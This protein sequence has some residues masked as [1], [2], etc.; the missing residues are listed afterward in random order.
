LLLFIILALYW[1]G[2]IVREVLARVNEPNPRVTLDQDGNYSVFM[3]D[4]HRTQGV[5]THLAYAQDANNLFSAAVPNV[6][7]RLESGRILIQSKNLKWLDSFGE[8]ADPPRSGDIV[9]AVYAKA[10]KSREYDAWWQQR[11]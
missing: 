8:P 2:G 3:N 9:F 10:H 4:N 11:P 5:I 1:V 6:P 7:L